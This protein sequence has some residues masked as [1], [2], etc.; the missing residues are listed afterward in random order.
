[1]NVDNNHCDDC[2]VLYQHRKTR[3]TR[4]LLLMINLVMIA[5]LVCKGLILFDE[6]LKAS[7]QDSSNKMR[8]HHQ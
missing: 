3:K 6:L 7:F 2:F 8:L 5:L 4:K 1:M